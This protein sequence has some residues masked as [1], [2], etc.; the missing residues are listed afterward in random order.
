MRVSPL[1][2]RRRSSLSLALLLLG[3]L[4]L[5]AVLWLSPRLTSTAPL[6]H[7]NEPI[8]VR[9][10]GLS[11]LIVYDG[12]AASGDGLIT[13]RYVANLLGHFGIKPDIRHISGYAGGLAEQFNATFVC[14][15]ASDTSMPKSLLVDL[16]RSEKPV[17]WINRHLGQ[18]TSQPDAA[19]R[20]G[21]SGGDFLDDEE[22]STVIYKGMTLP[23]HDSE[24][25]VIKITDAARV[26]IIATARDA[27]GE[28]PYVVRS[29]SF[30]YFADSV[31]GFNSE[32]DRSIVFADL[33]H[34]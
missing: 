29:G 19:A 5:A 2:G 15:L 9:R 32:S 33:L 13:A 24:I 18:F 1:S 17:C 27:N 34:D 20:L 10:S 26:Q 4:T 25:N 11:S 22:Y 14:G 16:A 28:I 31:F 12:S 23:K 21:F 7:G 6:T 8:A 30:W 3:L